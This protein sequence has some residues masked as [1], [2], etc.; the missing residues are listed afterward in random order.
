MTTVP[1]E[2]PIVLQI[3]GMTCAACQSHVTQ[4]LRRVSGVASAEVNLL[5]HEARVH[6]T[7]QPPAVATLVA[8]VEAA[9]Y[10]ASALIPDDA[11]VDDGTSEFRTARRDAIVLLSAGAVAMGLAMTAMHAPSTPWILLALASAAML[12]SGRGFYRRAWNALRHGGADMNVLIALGTS[13]AWLASAFSLAVDRRGMMA[14]DSNYAEAILFILGFVQL[15]RALDARAR[16]AATSAIARLGALRPSEALVERDGVE[17]RVALSQIRIDDVVRVVPGESIP[18]DAVVLEGESGV[19]E[20][21]LTGEPIPVLKRPGDAVVGG[22]VAVDGALR[23]RVVRVG[24]ATVLSRIIAAVRDAQ[25]ARAPIQELADRVS[26]SFVPAVA[27]IALLTLV[28]WGGIAH[29]WA[30]GLRSMIAVLIIACPCAMGLAVPAAVMVATGRAAQAGILFRGAIPLQRAATIDLIAFDKTGTL[31]MGAPTV[32]GFTAAA[33]HE[34]A[35]VLAQATALARRSEHPLA[36]AIAAY[37]A[38]ENAETREASLVRARP[39]QGVSGMV[40]GVAIALGSSAFLTGRGVVIP[41]DAATPDT[42]VHVAVAGAHAGTFVLEDTVRAESTEAVRAARAMAVDVVLL[43]GDRRVVAEALAARVGIRRVEADLRPEGKVA[44]LRA[45]QA[46]GHRVAMVGDGINDAPALAAA[47]VGIAMGS[48]SDIAIDAADI[49][50]LRSDPVRAV[51][52]LQI[53]RAA[54]RVMRQNLGWAFGYNVV[55]IPLAAGVLL[56][57]TGLALSPSVASAAMALSSV[58]VVVN[59]LRLQR[60]RLR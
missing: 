46:E 38:E 44:A 30:T 52:A 34:R 4:A 21:M 3:S 57:S 26:A 6:P 28:A 41:D 40:D 29:D 56:P 47:D 32:N 14:M 19:D 39:G 43:S 42:V 54:M 2:R 12:T 13:A 17:Q 18:V 5:M 25:G 15:G 11:S 7:A 24:E 48:G 36:K 37:G 35:V 9:G 8:A 55:G 16:G 33:A 1:A 50:L 53:A 22:S 31:T 27:A 45:W 51:H 49:A 23:L 60:L 20:A 59:S 10:G 58:S